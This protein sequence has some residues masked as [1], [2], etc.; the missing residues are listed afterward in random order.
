[1]PATTKRE[2]YD[3]IRRFV[4]GDEPVPETPAAPEN[5]GTDEVD[6]TL[7][8]ASIPD[9]DG[10]VWVTPEIAELWMHRNVNNRSLRRSRVD[11]FARDMAGERWVYTGEAVKFD[12]DGNLLDGQHRLAGVIKSGATIK[13]LVIT[14]LDPGSQAYMDA[15]AQ[16]TAGDALGFRGEVHSLLLASTCRLG[17]FVE[18]VVQFGGNPTRE[19][20]THAEVVDWLTVHPE[21]R[22][23]V[24][25]ASRYRSR[26][27]V[28]PSVLAY[29]LYRM[30]E[31][32]TKDTDEF[33]SAIV[34]MRSDGP[35]D[36]IYTLLMRLRN[37]RRTRERLTQFNELYFITKAW[38]A[39]RTG[40][41]LK[42]LK[43]P[44]NETEV[45][46]FL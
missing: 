19:T 23:Y 7:V 42:N 28:K 24:Q 31:R 35:G 6:E 3:P 34:D 4:T 11:A 40:N 33:L 44:A 26:L 37:A 32:D 10:P 14:Q 17:I 45:I 18:R 27:D 12:T 16:R 13:M 46:R 36:P 41:Q 5:P 15:G 9:S 22:R 8:A 38:N 1:M 25:A 43:V 39:F 20:V 21:V 30:G 2:T 29:A